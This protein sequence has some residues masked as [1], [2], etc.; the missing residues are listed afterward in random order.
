[1]R[2]DRRVRRT[3]AMLLEVAAVLA[4]IVVGGKLGLIL[5]L[6]A[7]SVVL[8]LRGGRWFEARDAG[9]GT[10]WAALGGLAVGVAAL[11]AAWA[12]APSLLD[13]TGRAVEWGTE[14]VV[15]GSASLAA[16]VMLVTLTFAVATEMVFRRWLL[17]R[18]A[19][20]VLARGESRGAALAAGVLVAA[21]IEAAVSPT[22]DGLRIGTALMA[23]GLGAVY[24][25]SGG[26]LAAC[27]GARVAFE[28]G[29]VALQALRMTA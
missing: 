25:S 22:G 23:G 29:A 7:G 16:T 14:P 9:G 26:R 6:V 27:V 17:D 13:V 4:A 1:V 3:A 10:G 24:V 20:A 19:A 12:I 8:A 11:A 18:V 15:R 28:L 2:H 5:L 21:L